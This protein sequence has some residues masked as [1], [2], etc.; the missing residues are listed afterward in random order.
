MNVSLI[1]DTHDH[2]DRAQSPRH[3]AGTPVAN[4]SRSRPASPP[5]SH[6]SP[7]L[8]NYSYNQGRSSIPAQSSYNVQRGNPLQPTTTTAQ[9]TFSNLP[10]PPPP[11][12]L[13][14]SMP[15]MSGASSDGHGRSSMDVPPPFAPMDPATEFATS[16]ISEGA[17]SSAARSR[18][19]SPPRVA[20]HSSPPPRNS[21]RS[22]GQL[23]AAQTDY[24]MQRNLPHQPSGPR[25]RPSNAYSQQRVVSSQQTTR[26]PP[27]ASPTDTRSSQPWM[28]G[29]SSDGHGRGSMDV[30]PPFA[31]MDPSLE[32]SNSPPSES[33]LSGPTSPP[34][35]PSNISEARYLVPP[36]PPL[37]IPQAPESVPSRPTSSPSPQPAA[38][39]SFRHSDIPSP[40][41]HT[42]NASAAVRQRLSDVPSAI[43][44]P[45]PIAVARA[46][47]PPPPPGFPG[48]KQAALAYQFDK[49]M[50][51]NSR[52]EAMSK[53]AALYASAMGK[54]SAPSVRVDLNTMAYQGHGQNQASPGVKEVYQPGSF[55]SYVIY[56]V[57]II[58]G[59]NT[60]F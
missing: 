28:S 23:P 3:D 15:W 11:P 56:S 26:S 14:G 45:A 35:A 40:S 5:P 58:H 51:L 10:P 27:P 43:G 31:A 60:Q 57:L 48:A 52:P 24:S 25:S 36:P 55:Y 19:A 16:P 30:P 39:P 34:Q 17:N 59:S 12:D 32:F 41:V 7:P 46:P 22:P 54:T 38:I 50:A 49:K 13:S 47:P 2:V 6:S 29:A 20:A 1:K 18:A 37:N 53:A 8:Q 9:S 33:P 21:T 42:P 4:R 44:R